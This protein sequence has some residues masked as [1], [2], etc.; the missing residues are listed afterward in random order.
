MRG[1]RG[2]GMRVGRLRGGD[3]GGWLRGRDEGQA[4]EGRG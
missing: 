1:G 2:E 3:E 4:T